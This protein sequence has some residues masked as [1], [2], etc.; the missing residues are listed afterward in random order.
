MR[1]KNSLSFGVVIAVLNFFTGALHAQSLIDLDFRGDSN[2]VKSGFAATGKTTNDYWNVV[3][4]PWQN[5]GT[6]ENLKDADGTDTTVSA[7]LANGG[8]Y[9]FN[10]TRDSM[11]DGYVYPNSGGGDGVGNLTVTVSNLTAD[12][13]DVY[14]YGNAYPHTG[15]PTSRGE[16]DTIF[17]ASSGGNNYGPTG[18]T[19][20]AGWTTSQ[21]WVEG[22]EYVLFRNVQVVAGQPLIISG[23]PGYNGQPANGPEH[24]ASLNGVQIKQSSMS[25]VVSFTNG[26]FET[27]VFSPGGHGFSSGSTDIIHWI[28]GGSGMVSIVNGPASPSVNPEDGAQQI[29]FNGGD[30]VPGATLSQTFSTMAGQTYTVSFYVGRV[31]TSEGTMSL[32]AQV[33]SSTGAALGSVT[34]VAPD[35]QGYGPVQTFNFTA[36]TTNSTLTFTDTS[37]ATVA[38]DLLLDNV[39]VQASTLPVGPFTNGSFETPALATGASVDLPAGSTTLT[40]WTVGNTGLVSW[41][42]GPAFGVAPV[43]GSQEVG[44][45]GANTPPGGSIFQTF[46]TTVGQTYT[47]SFNVGRQG[48]GGGTMSLQA[49]VTSS[50]GGALGSLTAVAPNSPGYGLAQTF[51]FTATTD[52]S[53]LTFTDTS[54][55]TIAVDLLLDNVSVAANSGCVAPPSGLISWWK[56]EGNGMDSVG[57]NNGALEGNAAFAPGLVGQAFS[58]DG[59]SDGVSFGNPASLQLQNFTIEAWVKRA[60]T[61]LASLDPVFTAGCVLGYGYGGYNFVI[62]NDGHLSLGKVGIAAVDSNVTVKDT[63]WH[64]VAVT[65]AAGNVVFYVDGVGETTPAFDPGFTFASDV[66]IGAFQ[67]SGTQPQ[68]SFLGLIDEVSIYNRALSATEVGTIF[69]A[70]SAGKC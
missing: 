55:A 24:P 52:S 54:T 50:T 70:G 38:V 40:G 68:G 41:R 48:T 65:K 46:S 69:T 42:N 13:Y 14:L 43:D 63:S 56:G 64:H 25:S 4:F 32:Q 1:L 57:S 27:P 34:A 51:N 19:L 2:N 10:S 39:S 35:T 30:T 62:R 37:T 23:A 36:T 6:V 33:T 29:D 47:V 17:S 8:G 21:P 58:F 12:R 44:F 31:G 28:T 3:S 7:T 9:W 22:K 59:D 5:L 26:S 60:D 11:F 45:N 61:N 15:D 49:Q 16:C 66:Q 67:W 53:T 18:T 20:S